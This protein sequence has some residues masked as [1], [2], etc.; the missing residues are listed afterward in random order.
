MITDKEID[1]LAKDFK[2]WRRTRERRSEAFVV[3]SKG[4]SYAFQFTY[5]NNVI[6]QETIQNDAHNR[7]GKIIER[8][9]NTAEGLRKDGAINYALSLEG[10]INDLKELILGVRE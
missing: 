1:E 6:S 8:M 7:L 5:P 4:T 9:E 3:G 10:Q 2:E